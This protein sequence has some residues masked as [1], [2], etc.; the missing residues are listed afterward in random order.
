MASEVQRLP[1]LEGYLCVAGLDRARVRVS[2]CVPQKRQVEFVRFPTEGHE[3]SRSGNPIHR[4]MRFDIIL[5][6]LGR[7]LKKG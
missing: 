6:W 4:Q 3:L 1:R 2:L 7:Y 5:E